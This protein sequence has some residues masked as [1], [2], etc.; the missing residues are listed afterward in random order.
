M[1][2]TVTYYEIL[3]KDGT[4]I[5]VEDYNFMDLRGTDYDCVMWETIREPGGSWTFQ[6]Y[7]G[8]LIKEVRKITMDVV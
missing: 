5:K 6:Q 1:P 7:P 2:N 8:S 3:K 4:I